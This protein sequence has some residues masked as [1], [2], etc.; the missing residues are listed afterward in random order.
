MQKRPI[1]SAIALR[2]MQKLTIAMIRGRITPAN[3]GEE[4]NGVLRSY[5]KAQYHIRNES[6][7][8][9]KF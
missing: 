8:A 3:H 5:I 7:S 4:A 6:S 2:Y 9:Q 1:V